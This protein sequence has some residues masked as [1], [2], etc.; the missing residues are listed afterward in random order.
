MTNN[1]TTNLVHEW[2]LAQKIHASNSESTMIAKV[3]ARLAPNPI[4]PRTK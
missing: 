2:L 3:L 1:F 4:L